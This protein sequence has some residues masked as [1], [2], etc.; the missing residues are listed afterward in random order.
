MSYI[1]IPG[2]VVGPSHLRNGRPCEDSFAT[3]EADGWLAAVVCD[4]CGSVGHAREGATFISEYVAK[5]LAALGLKLAERGFGEWVSGPIVET[6]ADL[7]DEMRMRFN[8]DIGDYAATVVGALVSRDNGLLVHIGDGIASAFAISLGANGMTI[9]PQAQSDPE[10]GDY[11]NETYYVTD[12]GWLK[13]LRIMPIRDPKCLII[14]TDGAQALLY[15]RNTLS[16]PALTWLLREIGETPDAA[17]QQLDAFLH[18]PEAGKR[19]DDDKTVV[20]LISDA[21]WSK[22]AG[23]VVAPLP[24]VARHPVVKAR[25]DELERPTLPSALIT[26]PVADRGTQLS[27]DLARTRGLLTR[28]RHRLWAERIVSLIVICLVAMTVVLASAEILPVPYFPTAK[29]RALVCTEP[30]AAPPH[31]PAELPTQICGSEGQPECPR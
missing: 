9:E 5:R 19:S 23:G 8:G 16:L 17:S 30:P 1:C 27:A 22:I 12:A 29:L 4:G 13:H 26:P 21:A 24:A 28:A 18:D 2:S 3:C 10:N 15:E 6:F 31:K 11:S 7:R 14:C 25:L 20:L